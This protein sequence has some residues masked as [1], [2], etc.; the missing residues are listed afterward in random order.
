MAPADSS[1]DLRSSKGFKV[2]NTMPE[3]GLLVNPLML[4]PGKA[5]A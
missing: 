2:T 4:K 1:L 5:T 3:L